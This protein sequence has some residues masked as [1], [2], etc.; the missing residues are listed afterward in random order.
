MSGPL[1]K[2]RQLH[3]YAMERDLAMPPTPVA[4]AISHTWKPRNGP[5]IPVYHRGLPR[6][7]LPDLS[8][9]EKERCDYLM[10]NRSGPD[11]IGPE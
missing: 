8:E 9:E 2:E 1:E 7:L 6:Q 5:C 10:G 11:Y 4:Y 3:Y